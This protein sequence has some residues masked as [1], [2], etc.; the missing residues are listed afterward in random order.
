LIKFRDQI[1]DTLKQGDLERSSVILDLDRNGFDS[2]YTYA[3]IDYWANKAINE[4][5]SSGILFQ[6]SDGLL[7]L[8]TRKLYLQSE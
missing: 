5:I 7:G 8:I 4:M 1:I 6:L 2:E 3:E